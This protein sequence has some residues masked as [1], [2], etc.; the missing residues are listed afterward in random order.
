MKKI[1]KGKK[2]VKLSLIEC[3]NLIINNYILNKENKYL[4]LY[5]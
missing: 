3:L 4:F 1:V 5:E 2:F